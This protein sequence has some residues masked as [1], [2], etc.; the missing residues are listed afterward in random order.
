MQEELEAAVS[1]WLKSTIRRLEAEACENQ[2][3]LGPED[4]SRE[5][6]AGSN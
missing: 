5:A 1:A 6:G 4:I 3:D 2:V